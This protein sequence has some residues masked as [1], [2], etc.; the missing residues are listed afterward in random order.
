M[1]MLTNELA[2]AVA[3]ASS[4]QGDLEA[5]TQMHDSLRQQLQ[6]KSDEVVA[7]STRLEAEAL[8]AQNAVEEIRRTKAAEIETLQQN[9]ANLQLIS[10]ETSQV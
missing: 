1:E 5:A 4:R 9:L 2:I 3:L 10:Q 7:L 8:L 6:A